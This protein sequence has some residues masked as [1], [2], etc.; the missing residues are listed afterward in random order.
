MDSIFCYENPDT[1]T[2]EGSDLNR[3][4]ILI[5]PNISVA[6]WPTEAGSK[7]L[8]NFKAMEDATIIRKLRR[9]GAELSSSTHMSEFGFGLQNSQA[10][11]AV[12]QK[13]AD[14]E[15]VLDLMGESRLAASRAAVCSLKPSYGLISRFGLIGLIPSMECYGILSGNLKNIRDILKT[16]SGP[17]ERDFSVPEEKF[18]DFSLSQIDPQKTTIGVIIEAQKSLSPEQESAFLSSL[19]EFKKAGFSLKELSQPEF[20]LF[21]LV[22]NIVGSVEAS[23]CAGRYDSVRYGQRAP[24]AKN[25]NEMY[26]QSRNAAFGTL[27]K[28]YLIQGAFFQFEKY[29]S[30]EDACRIRGRLISKMQ[31]LTSEVDFLILPASGKASSGASTP[32]AETYAQFALTSFANV[33]GQPVLYLPP[34]PGGA[35]TGF[36][37]TGP[38][39]GDARLLVLGEYLLNS[40]QGGY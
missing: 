35:Q 36:Q 39:L 28:S 7:A 17:D 1:A 12:R 29:E 14:A 19:E 13:I 24:G 3:L 31:Q 11:E 38:R 2:P 21:S 25:W 22:H 32:L 30:F 15:L 9:A 4:K 26:L 5:Q 34:A 8:F 10:G 27:L 16:I 23:S 33:S 18:P 20:E 6:G 37:L 40:R